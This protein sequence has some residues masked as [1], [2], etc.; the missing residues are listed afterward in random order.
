M[1]ITQ[2]QQRFLEEKFGQDL[3]ST[4][5]LG[6]YTWAPHIPSGQIYASG[7]RQAFGEYGVVFARAGRIFDVRESEGVTLGDYRR[8]RGVREFPDTP[9]HRTGFTVTPAQWDAR[10]AELRG[11]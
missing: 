2:Q 6:C 8:G 7:L 3:T 10:I 4:E 5:I 11:R 1:D 9:E